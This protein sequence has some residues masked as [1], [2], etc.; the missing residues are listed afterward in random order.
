MNAAL[1]V[2]SLA[3]F[4]FGALSACSDEPAPWATELVTRLRCGMS[5]NDVQ[6]SAGREV[7]KLDPRR[8][9]ATHQVGGDTS[10]TVVW[11]VFESDRLVSAQLAWM[12]NLKRMHEGTK[13]YLCKQ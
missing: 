9:W 13:Q 5:P 8:D 4:V 7:L 11:L 3:L 10:Q 1:R 12:Y 2:A 6:K